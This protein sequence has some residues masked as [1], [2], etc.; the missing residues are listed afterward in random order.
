MDILGKI[1]RFFK[2]EKEP[3]VDM[4]KSVYEMT[5]SEYNRYLKRLKSDR[6]YAFCERL[7]NIL[8][9]AHKEYIS[10]CKERG[11]YIEDHFFIHIL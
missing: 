6:F 2:G 10:H 8:P 7:K 9:M 5:Q 1:I 3:D 4:S 11:Y